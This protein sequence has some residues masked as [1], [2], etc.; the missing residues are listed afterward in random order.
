VILNGWKK[1]AASGRRG[2]VIADTNQLLDLWLRDSAFS[3]SDDRH[4]VLITIDS[5][6]RS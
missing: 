5:S 2:A 1:I 6:L 4:H 3:R